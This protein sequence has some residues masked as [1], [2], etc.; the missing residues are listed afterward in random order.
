MALRGPMRRRSQHRGRLALPSFTPDA[1]ARWTV[2][3][4]AGACRSS[5]ADTSTGAASAADPGRALSLHSTVQL[6]RG[7]QMPLFGLGTW[8]ATN[9]GECK[10]AVR[11]ALQLGFRLIDTAQMYDNHEDVRAALQEL[12]AD[13]PRPFVVSKLSPTPECHGRAGAMAQLDRTL[14]EL[15]LEQLD[16]WLMHSPSP[17]K[18]LETWQAMLSARD[19]GKV[20][21][22]GVSNFGP[23]QLEGLKQAGC[24]VPE[25]NQ[26]ELH[27]WNQQR[28]L[29]SYCQR[30]G[31]AV[32]SFCPLARC[33]LFGQTALQQIA[34]ETGQSEAALAIRWLL[35]KVSAAL[36]AARAR[37]HVH[38]STAT[39]AVSCVQV[40][41]SGASG[42]TQYITP[43]AH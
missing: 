10:D 28:E 25:V 36:R 1:A 9:G 8:L 24:D 40:P 23:E 17:G 13:A 22:V 26:F 19:A 31:I 14:E 34:L 20:R 29:V 35:Q 2:A 32:M 37:T 15:G 18:V 21:A 16:L 3:A 43:T 39:E 12:P 5:S 38:T 4:A 33:K 11:A 42:R 27:C 7:L 6:R 30:E 41:A